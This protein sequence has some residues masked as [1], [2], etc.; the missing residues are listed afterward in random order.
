M[1]LTL[2]SE[3]LPHRMISERFVVI[4]VESTG[5]S[6]RKDYHMLEV[7]A[8]AIR[9]GQIIEEFTTFI[10]R[11]KDIPQD[12]GMPQGNTSPEAKLHKLHS[13]IADSVL[14]A[15]N[16]RSEVDFLFKEFADISLPLYND[17][18]CTLE[19]SRRRF[20]FLRNHHLDTVAHYVLGDRPDRTKLRRAIDDARLA[21]RVW[22]ALET[23]NPLQDRMMC[24]GSM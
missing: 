3:A 17:Y 19:L 16:A 8:V 18:I 9:D 7:G 23:S 22:L 20:P 10:G 1:Q 5:V 12:K 24:I 2:R 14:V 6:P 13:F 11:G 15:H 21:S 4:D